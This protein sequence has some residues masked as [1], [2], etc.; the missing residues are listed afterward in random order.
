M[1]S[2]SGITLRGSFGHRQAYSMYE[3]QTKTHLFQT[4]PILYPWQHKMDGN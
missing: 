4:H 1:S 2:E 3:I